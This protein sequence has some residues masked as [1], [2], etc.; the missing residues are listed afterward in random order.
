[1][2]AGV[3]GMAKAVVITIHGVNPDRGWQPAVHEVLKA[4]FDCLP[5]EYPDYDSI[6]GPVRAVSNVGLL[7]ISAIALLLILDAVIFK[8]WWKAA[9]AALVFAT[10]FPLGLALGWRRIEHRE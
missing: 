2:C 10:A 5:Y 4:H 7:V 9:F 1:M 8:D 6:I 3:G